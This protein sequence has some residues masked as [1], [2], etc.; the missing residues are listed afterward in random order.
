MKFLGLLRTDRN[1]FGVRDKPL[2]TPRSDGGPIRSTITRD[3]E[4]GTLKYNRVALQGA[5][6][7][8]ADV[9]PKDILRVFGPEAEAGTLIDAPVTM[10]GQRKV[11][12]EREAERVAAY[13]EENVLPLVPTP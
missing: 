11:I 6:L 7:A 13:I 8:S 9:R 4:V 1:F 3:S 10:G 5:D 2:Q 12:A